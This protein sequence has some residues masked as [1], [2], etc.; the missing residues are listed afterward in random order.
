MSEMQML[1]FGQW[2]RPDVHVIFHTVSNILLTEVQQHHLF[3]DNGYITAD[4]TN[5]LKLR[6][7]DRKHLENMRLTW[8]MLF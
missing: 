4:L 8:S 6:L 2:S 3:N 5:K 7:V 1:S